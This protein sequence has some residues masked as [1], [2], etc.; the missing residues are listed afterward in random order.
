MTKFTN[1]NDFELASDKDVLNIF[2]MINEHEVLYEL[3]PKNFN[4]WKNEIVSK[5][6]KN[7]LMIFFQ[8]NRLNIIESVLIIEENSFY[9]NIYISFLSISLEERLNV[10]VLK[11]V[12]REI[13]DYTL[14]SQYRK[15][16]CATNISNIK[17]QSILKKLGFSLIEKQESK[18]YYSISVDTFLKIK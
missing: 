8:K 3:E 16:R 14:E 18:I 17:M 15:I 13:V 10:R 7:K 1:A 5:M 11:N 6:I 9:S 2:K 4:D 12:L